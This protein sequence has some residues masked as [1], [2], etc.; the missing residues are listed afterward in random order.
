MHGAD[1]PDPQR[2]FASAAAAYARYRP[3]YPPALIEHLVARCGLD[4]TGRLLDL[5]CGTGHLALLLAAR[6]ADVIGLDPNPDMLAEAARQAALAGV[7][8]ARWLLGSDADLPRLGPQLA[9][10]RLVTI[11][12]AFHWMDQTATLRALDALVAPGGTVVVTADSDPVWHDERFRDRGWEETIRAALRRWLGE[13]RRAGDG[14]HSVRHAPFEDYLAA[15]PFAR[16]E[17]FT[18]NY[19]RTWSV[20]GLLGY[21]AST[22]YAAPRL[23]GAR[24]PAFAAELRAELLALNPAGAFT[25]DV[26]LDA[27]LA[28]RE[29]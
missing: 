6:F 1:A 13:Q 23:F 21:L 12:R 8:N 29:R 3:A 9:P 7:G 25:Q 18:L 11:G 10:L 17:V 2:L 22:S 19:T 5:G 24:Q 15:S 27:W 20:E 26:I 16:V 14:V 4:G 28:T